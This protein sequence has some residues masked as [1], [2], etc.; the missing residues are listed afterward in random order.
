M[1]TTN[2]NPSF[3]TIVTDPSISGSTLENS[4]FKKHKRQYAEYKVRILD[5]FFIKDD[6]CS[7]FLR[8]MRCNSFIEM[9]KVARTYI[10]AALS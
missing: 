4:D 7:I 8:L 5:D 9:D 2:Y 3:M 6:D 1:K 10:D